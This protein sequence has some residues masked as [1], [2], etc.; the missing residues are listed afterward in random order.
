MIGDV[1]IITF[2]TS[3][4]NRLVEDGPLSEA[5]LAGIK[6]GLFFRF[7]GLSIE[8]LVSTSE[9]AKRVALFTYC[10]R[11]QEGP[12]V[13][14]HPQNELIRLLVA[15][16]FKNPSTFNWMTVDELPRAK[17]ATLRLPS[18]RV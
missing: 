9:S 1:P 11:L 16:H 7:A 3:A 13:C 10:A 15:E 14:L 12:S 17:P 6:S 18:T 4:H 8:E 5:V 2:D